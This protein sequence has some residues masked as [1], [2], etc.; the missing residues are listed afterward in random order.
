MTMAEQFLHLADVDAGIQKQGRSGGQQR[1]GAVEPLAI[2][3]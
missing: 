3:N 1:V 2:P